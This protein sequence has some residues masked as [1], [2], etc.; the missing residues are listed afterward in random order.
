ML[1]SL[2]NTAQGRGQ[3]ALKNKKIFFWCCKPL[4]LY[5]L[6]KLAQIRTRYF[7]QLTVAGVGI[8]S[9]DFYSTRIAALAKMYWPNCRVFRDSFELE[10]EKNQAYDLGFCV[11]FPHKISEQSIACCKQGIVNLHFAPL[12][13]YRGSGTLEKALLDDADRFGLTL[14]FIDKDLDTGDVIDKDLLPITSTDTYVT[15]LPRLERLGKEMIDRWWPILLTQKV[16][17]VSQEQLMTEEGSTSTLCTRKK[18]KSYYVLSRH[19]SF[20]DLYLQVRAL[21]RGSGNRPYFEKN[22]R[23]IYLTLEL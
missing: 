3:F 9:K 2:S 22:G 14:H 12:P 23:K 8:S 13:E 10:Q 19:D 15:L 6:R 20:D 4:G 7:P 16:T 1:K 21:D 5:G 17:G 11:G 18:T